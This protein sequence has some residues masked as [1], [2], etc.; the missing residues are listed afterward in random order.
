MLYDAR[1]RPTPSAEIT[2]RL[3]QID[4][5]LHLRWVEQ[6]QG[7]WWAVAQKWRRGDQRYKLIQQ[8]GMHPD[9]DW[10][11]L[12]GLP[13]DC[14]ADEAYGYIINTL[15]TASPTKQSARDLL[16]RVHLYNQ[17]SNEA[18]V[19]EIVEVAEE[20]GEKLLSKK[21]VRVK[22]FQTR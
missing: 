21:K 7:G 17:M 9:D 20:E 11:M 18:T 3:E 1:G 19:R 13:R 5:A 12:L 22:V 14:T 15:R 16:S 10:D 8:G 4:P 6:E 2:K